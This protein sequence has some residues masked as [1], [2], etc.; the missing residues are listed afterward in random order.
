MRHQPPG[1]AGPIPAGASSLSVPADRGDGSQFRENSNSSLGQQVH[2]RPQ[3]SSTSSMGGTM[4]PLRDLAP[5]R[6]V[7]E[8][9]RP[10]D[11]IPIQANTM[12]ARPGTGPIQQ[13]PLT[14]IQQSMQPL[15]G[16]VGST[17][18]RRPLGSDSQ[19]IPSQNQPPSQGSQYSHQSIP[20]KPA[21]AVDLERGLTLS[22]PL[23]SRQGTESS[24]PNDK[25][26]V[27]SAFVPPL[28][29]GA[30][31]AFKHPGS[32]PIG[33]Q[34][35]QTKDSDVSLNEREVHLKRVST[36]PPKVGIDDF[37]VWSL[38]FGE[39]GIDSEVPTKEEAKDSAPVLEAEQPQPAPPAKDT[40]V[41]Q[42]LKPPA[43]I[44]RDTLDVS[45]NNQ[46]Q[47]MT[48][49][50]TTYGDTPTS[51]APII[52]HH[53]VDDPVTRTGSNSGR[54][55]MFPDKRKGTEGPTAVDSSLAPPHAEFSSHPGIN[56]RPS[57]YPTTENTSSLPNP[58]PTGGEEV[59]PINTGTMVH[60]ERNDMISPAS[61]SILVDPSSRSTLPLASSATGTPSETGPPRIRFTSRPTS[62]RTPSP[63]NPNS[64]GRA[65]KE[66]ID[67]GNVGSV[68]KNGEEAEV[69]GISMVT[70]EGS[71]EKS[72]ERKAENRLSVIT[73][74]G[75]H[76]KDG[77]SQP[78]TRTC[79]TS[80]LFSLSVGL[81]SFLLQHGMNRLPLYLKCQRNSSMPCLTLSRLLLDP[82]IIHLMALQAS[83]PP[84]PL[85]L[86][87]NPIQALISKIISA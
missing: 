67:S 56:R 6:P 43:S 4:P 59:I 11:G 2:H 84:I 13:A 86:A 47:V 60:L 49:T 27:D 15:D 72:A 19:S 64:S 68:G 3:Q 42:D 32:P 5:Q 58:L 70:T 28:P 78:T 82:L 9:G 69:T 46:T 16:P 12:P 76:K 39:L 48:Q 25:K 66:D 34:R 54:F 37:P 1:P 79:C 10:I 61:R 23:R 57:P 36:L 63:V 38:G 71:P 7:D 62:P 31:S 83:A 41:V 77:N 81:I 45:S 65:S 85:C 87:R 50:P 21:P 40:V 55:A 75:I 80:C 29:S 35:Q 51:Y 22:L 30:P 17:R 52:Q 53:L 73:P 26:E 14:T 8:F 44:S 24:E 33:L 74:L 20:R 18:S